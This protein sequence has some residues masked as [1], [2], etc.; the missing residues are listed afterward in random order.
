MLHRFGFQVHSQSNREGE[1]AAHLVSFKAARILDLFQVT[2]SVS[3]L[4][5][6]GCVHINI[7][8]GA[9][10]L[11]SEPDSNCISCSKSYFNV[12]VV[13]L[14]FCL[15]AHADPSECLGL[16]QRPVTAQ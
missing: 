5:G 1:N 8:Q 2:T 11:C 14:C 9:F 7:F 3:F 12:Q 10:V 4:F 13:K 16:S 6:V 15:T